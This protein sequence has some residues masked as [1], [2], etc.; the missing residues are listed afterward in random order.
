MF[1]SL[2]IPYMEP[3]NLKMNLETHSN[4]IEI[5]D[6]N[7]NVFQELTITGYNCGKLFF[8]KNYLNN[9][10]KNLL[11]IDEFCKQ[12]MKITILG[13]LYNFKLI[14]GLFRIIYKSKI[15]FCN[16][17]EYYEDRWIKTWIA[18]NQESTNNKIRSYLSSRACLRVL[19]DLIN[20]F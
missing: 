14:A 12:K 1:F 15:E 20:P 5:S 8:N 9:A 16:P 7:L 10:R 4:L 3:G 19:S 11:K 6:S 13:A 18:I 2:R 17:Q